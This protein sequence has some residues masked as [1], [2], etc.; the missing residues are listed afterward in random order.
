MDI[1]NN[2]K[3]L[4]PKDQ[5]KVTNLIQKL[6]NKT[7]YQSENTSGKQDRS[8]RRPPMTQI[9][10]VS[11][12][13][14]PGQKI[15]RESKV[16]QRSVMQPHKT[17][18]QVGTVDITIPIDAVD[19]PNLFVEQAEKLIGKQ[20]LNAHKSDVKIDQKLSGKNNVTSRGDRSELVDAKCRS[21][22]TV[23]EVS[24]KLVQ[25]DEDGIRFV[26]DNCQRGK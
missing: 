11:Q 1:V 12:Q 3:N 8:V 13:G 14:T 4:T 25:R 17:H 2:F 5:K 10:K 20:G 22:G 7:D 16:D 24:H 19:R 23:W 9:K 6:S 21:C 18:A 26:C 15:G